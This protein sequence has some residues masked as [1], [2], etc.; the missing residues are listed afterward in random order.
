MVEAVL[1]AAQMYSG[2]GLEIESENVETPNPYLKKNCLI[3]FGADDILRGA[4][5]PGKAENSYRP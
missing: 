5:L 1:P 4:R 3:L 2:P